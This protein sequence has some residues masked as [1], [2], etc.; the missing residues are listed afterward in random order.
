[1]IS[2]FK[3]AIESIKSK[4]L[5]NTAKIISDKLKYD[6]RYKFTAINLE[7]RKKFTKNPIV[8]NHGKYKFNY[9]GKGDIAEVLYH[10]FWDKL[11]SDELSKIRDSVKMGD[12]VIDVGGNLGFFVLI[13]N[14]L[15]G[16][17]GKIYSFEPSNQLNQKLA[18]TIKINNL[19]NVSIVNLALGDTEES[20]TLHY[21]PQQ[22]GL[23][24]IVGDFENN[25]LLEEIKIT[26]LD[27]FSQNISGRVSFIK[28]DTEGFEPKVL[29]GAK[30]LIKRDKPKIYIELGGDHQITSAESLK[31][32]NELNYYCEAENLDLSKIPA[33]VNFIAT[34][35]Q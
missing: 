15:V 23:S 3:K 22:S 28:I 33:G 1:M 21:N 13:L 24:S 29:K 8:I 32:L 20:T 12:I 34:P 16:S 14:E 6:S 31:I 26:T 35:N 11:F 19:K 9:Y 10:A 5:V 18:S 27:K 25:S 17:S 30:Q 2:N 4:G 7:L